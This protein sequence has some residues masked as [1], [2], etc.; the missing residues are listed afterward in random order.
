MKLIGI[1]PFLMALALASLSAT[2]CSKSTS[3]DS[4]PGRGQ[5]GLPSVPGSEPGA[6]PSPV[7][8][9]S[10]TPARPASLILAEGTPIK[11]RTTTTVST[12]SAR[13]GDSFQAVLEEP[14]TVDGIL[15]AD[16]GAQVDG[17]VAESNPGGR[18]KGRALLE[19]RL[20]RLHTTR[21]IIDLNT[22]ERGRQARGTKKRDGVIIGIGAG[23]GAAIGALAGGGKGAAIGAGAGGGAGTGVVL[24]TRGA[25][26]VIPAESVLTFRL[27]DAVTL[28]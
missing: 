2:G 22:N 16:R 14:L 18:V 13:S 9:G 4:T 5:T 11:V 12:K 7:A 1:T 10:R 17:I 24:G 20:A 25:P 27:Q 19:L 21:G 3:A 26:A 28:S 6:N 23:V 8:T 15:I